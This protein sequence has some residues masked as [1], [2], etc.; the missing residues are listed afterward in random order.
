MEGQKKEALDKL[1]ETKCADDTRC[2]TIG[3]GITKGITIPVTH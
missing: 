2:L 3:E 1:T